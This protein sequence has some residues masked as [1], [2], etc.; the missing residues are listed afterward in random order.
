MQI[1]YVEYFNISHHMERC[2]HQEWFPSRIADM[3]NSSEAIK[4]SCAGSST[5]CVRLRRLNPPDFAEEAEW[6]GPAD[7]HASLWQDL[8]LH[9]NGGTAGGGVVIH[10]DALARAPVLMR[11][12]SVT[13]GQGAVGGVHTAFVT[14][15]WRD[16]GWG[17]RKGYQISRL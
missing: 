5:R 11:L 16:Q 7:G 6:N 13:D 17:N 14:A 9:D 1:E 15:S 2:F 12:P 3:L 4:F 8:P 10:R